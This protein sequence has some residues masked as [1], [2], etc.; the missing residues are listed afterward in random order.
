MGNTIN[1]QGSYIDVHDNQNVYLSVD[2]AEVRMGQPCEDGAEKPKELKGERA[3]A[4]MERLVEAELLDD[5]WQ[6]VGLSGAEK[7]LVA[8][9]VGERL[10]IHEVWQVFG[11][12]WNVKPE[13]LRA[14]FN[15][16][17]EQ[18]KSL[19]F[20]DRLKKLFD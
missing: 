12:L 14:F 5:G 3:E 1:V 6:P 10:G 8:R 9:A 20:Q 2:K 4:L 7:A 18:R 16:A 13:S 11:R 19:G 17:L 15:R